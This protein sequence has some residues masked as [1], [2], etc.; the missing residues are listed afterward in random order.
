MAAW[1]GVVSC[2]LQM[3]LG[4]SR[5]SAYLTLP[6][7]GDRLADRA[8]HLF[9]LWIIRW[10]HQS[11]HAPSKLHLLQQ[12]FLLHL[13]LQASLRRSHLSGKEGHRPITL[14]LLL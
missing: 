7:Q 13:C 8:Q 5:G 12:L 3:H 14:V 2:A 4:Y 1:H 11:S 10:H 6:E 9:D